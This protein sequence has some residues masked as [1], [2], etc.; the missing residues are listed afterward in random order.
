MPFCSIRRTKTVAVRAGAQPNGP[1]MTV[2]IARRAQQQKIE[3]NIDAVTANLQTLERTSREPSPAEFGQNAFTSWWDALPARY[4]VV[5]ACAASF[6]ICNMDKVNMSVA[7]IPMAMDFGWSPSVSGIV[8]SSFF[9]G[10]MLCQL[11]GGIMSSRFGGRKVLPAGVALWSLATMGVPL[12]A[13]TIPGLCFSRAAVGLGEA[14]APSAATDMV[15]RCV[16]AHERS[17]AVSF[18]FG[19]LHVGSILG[20]L[21]APPLIS[22][23]GWEMVF[24]SFGALGLVWCLWFEQQLSA[25]AKQQPE[26]AASLVGNMTAPSSPEEDA[27][28][29]GGHGGVIDASS[30]IPWRA[31]LRSRAVQALMYTHFC[32]NWFHYTMLAWLPTYFTDTLSVDLMHA[33]QTAL[34]PPLAGIA[35]SAAAGPLADTLISKGLPLSTVRKLAQCTAFL[36][37]SALLLAACHPYVV[38]STVLTVAAITASLGISSFSLAGLYCTHQDMSPKYASAMLGLTNTIGAVPGILGVATVGLLFDATS[39]W[40]LALF[41]PS[42]AF[43]ITGAAA[44]TLYG[45][46]DPTDFDNLD[47]S[48]FAWEQRLPRLPWAAKK[49]E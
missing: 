47:N 26:V 49:E 38:D 42:A 3:P 41:V 11:P 24:F 28:H 17:R 6:V 2:K 25:L 15:A 7:I 22:N 29:S 34:L 35:A 20:L 14:V 37:P 32:N 13:S 18:I 33:A 44:Y 46:N 43:M 4:R 36:V 27:G 40:E 16:P 8:Q 19:G 21:A 39:S 1:R 23:F 12:L 30:P 9:Y 10:Y 45:R 48:P 5:V 31:F